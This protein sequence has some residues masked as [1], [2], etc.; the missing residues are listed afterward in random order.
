MEEIFEFLN[1]ILRNNNRPW[2]QEHKGL[3]LKADKKVQA[4]AEQ[5]IVGIEKFDNSIK[6][7]TVKDC[8]YRIYRDMRFSPDKRPY[9]THMGIF[10]C[11]NGKKANLAG[12]YFHLEA[13]GAEYLNQNGLFTGLYNPDG[14]MLK[15]IRNEV[16]FNGKI[17][18]DAIAAAK[19]FN[20]SQDGM[21]SRVP[22]GYPK[23]HKYANL[24]KQREWALSQAIPNDIL[25][26]DHLIE[27]TL[28]E[29]KSSMDLNRILNNAISFAPES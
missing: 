24:L 6:G 16:L 5:L 4:M 21:L 14:K 28:E 25:F 26:S 7:L 9:K 22:N 12:Y 27:W 15:N 1:G 8:T 23:D 29:F 10:V 2:F 11:P 19:N 13:D 18:E 3:Y 17:F 20:F